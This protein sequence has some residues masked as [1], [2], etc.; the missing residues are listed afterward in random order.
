[1]QG[2]KKT[3][4][5]FYERFRDW[6]TK[7]KRTGFQYNAKSNFVKKLNVGISKKVMALMLQ[8]QVCEKPMSMEKVLLVALEHNQQFLWAR[9]SASAIAGPSK[10][11][12]KYQSGGSKKRKTGKSSC[13]NCK[14]E[15][16]VVANFPKPKTTAQ[17]AWEA[18][19]ASKEKKV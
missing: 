4:Q 14:K 9:L 16:H 6:E 3:C 10:R 15:E 2:P 5:E 18:K 11:R 17:K 7:A 12:A 1:M 19:N 8:Q 13:F